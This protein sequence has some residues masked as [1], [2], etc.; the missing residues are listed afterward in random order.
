MK[1]THI[2]I[3]LTLLPL[4]S[5]CSGKGDV[6]RTEFLMDTVCTVTLFDSRPGPEIVF[7]RVFERIAEIDEKFGIASAGS[8]VR[9]FNEEKIPITDPLILSV[10]ETAVFVSEKT[11]GAFDIT[12]YP[13][14]KLW[15]FYSSSGK[16]RTTLPEENA[17]K[18]ALN[19]IGYEKLIIDAKK[20]LLP[21]NRLAGIDLGGIAKGFAVSE[22]CRIL[23]ENGIKSAIIDFGGDIYAL[24]DKKGKPWKIGI[25]DPGKE[26][27]KTILELKNKS[28]VTSG[29][30]QRYIEI[31]GKKYHHI[32]NPKT[33]YPAE[34]LSSV[35][36]IAD[37]NMLA[38]ALSTAFFVIADEIKIKTISNALG[39]D[40]YAVTQEGVVFHSEGLKQAP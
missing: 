2:I 5:S 23:K 19:S 25:K 36:V 3:L 33:G 12:V 35:T 16:K 11:T 7:D 26:G 8:I 40:Y 32:L 10:I 1:K 4:F 34:G 31:A 15:G 28:A 20:G 14:V 30:Y 22:A 18:E 29:N 38:D 17:L 6:S 9:K 27:I 13:L 21:R 24:G 39:V 37:N